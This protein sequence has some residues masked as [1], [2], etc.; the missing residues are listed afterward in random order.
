[1]LILFEAYLSMQYIGSWEA[2]VDPE[3]NRVYYW[4]TISGQLSF[5]IHLSFVHSSPLFGSGVT[6]WEKPELKED[7]LESSYSTYLEPSIDSSLV[8]ELIQSEE[9]R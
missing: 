5:L 1:M 9:S 4:N 6:Q 8:S 2:I 3:T 7:R